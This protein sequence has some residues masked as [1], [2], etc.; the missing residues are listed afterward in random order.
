M[1]SIFDAVSGKI[2]QK[3]VRKKILNRLL[4]E[5]Y[6]MSD[7]NIFMLV[8]NLLMI[9]L[10]FSSARDY[11]KQYVKIGR[12]RNG[13]KKIMKKMSVKE[14]IIL[15]AYPKYSKSTSYKLKYAIAINNIYLVYYILYAFISILQFIFSWFIYINAALFTFKMIVVDIPFEIF[16]FTHLVHSK[17]GGCEWRL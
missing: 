11:A 16:I 13:F 5:V 17:N 2:C 15:N 1:V 7:L 4:E 12:S 6:T 10:V 3:D 8:C 9:F 14:R